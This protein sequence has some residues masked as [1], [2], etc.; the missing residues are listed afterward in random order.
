MPVSTL[1]EIHVAYRR[2]SELWH[3]LFE[4]VLG[5]NSVELRLDK[6]SKKF[7]KVTTDLSV[8]LLIFSSVRSSRSRNVCLSVCP[9]F[10]SL[11]QKASY[12]EFHIDSPITIAYI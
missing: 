10:I 12:R 4:Q 5:S 3:V 8:Y 11:V 6:P 1:E 9:L 7:A 2:Y